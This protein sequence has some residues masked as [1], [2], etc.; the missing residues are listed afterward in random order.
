MAE[1]I[2]GKQLAKKINEQTKASVTVL[3]AR[4]I[5]PKL[6]VII[7]GDDE[8]SEIYVRNKHRKAVQIG[9]ISETKRLLK[10]PRKQR[11]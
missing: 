9:I 5:A 6:V 3:K 1:L 7:V 8:A 10:T 2:D 4:G 11:F